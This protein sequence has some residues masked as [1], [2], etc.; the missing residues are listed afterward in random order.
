MAVAQEGSD[1]VVV[2]YRTFSAKCYPPVQCS[3]NS[4]DYTG[5]FFISERLVADL[6]PEIRLT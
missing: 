3:F 2:S 4:P 6:F 5:L 1:S